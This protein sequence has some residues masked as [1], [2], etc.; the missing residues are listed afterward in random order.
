MTLQNKYRWSKFK[1]SAHKGEVLMHN[2]LSPLVIYQVL[3]GIYIYFCK[4]LPVIITETEGRGGTRA[5]TLRGCTFS[6]VPAKA[7]R[8]RYA[9]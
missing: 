2:H 5:E 1:S 9:L 7:C 3:C 4:V 8:D 6:S